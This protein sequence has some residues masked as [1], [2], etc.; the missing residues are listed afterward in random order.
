MRVIRKG[1]QEECLEL[2]E[3]D[4]KVFAM[5]KRPSYTQ[6]QNICPEKFNFD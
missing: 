4:L 6:I 5:K 3:P 1:Q 2:A